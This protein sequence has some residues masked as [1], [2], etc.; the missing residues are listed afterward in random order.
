[1]ANENPILN[2]PY[3]EPR[4]HYATNL[5]GELDY[6]SVVQGRRLFR[7][8][9]PAIPVR[10]RGQRHLMGVNDLPDGTPPSDLPGLLKTNTGTCGAW[11]D[12]LTEALHDQGVSGAYASTIAP[13]QI[14]VNQLMGMPPPTPQQL[15]PNA[16][17]L[18]LYAVIKPNLPGQGNP[19]PKN[20]FPG[21]MQAVNGAPPLAV[22]GLHVVVVVNGVNS[23][24][25][26]SYGARD[27][28][29]NLGAAEQA[30]QDAA[31]QRWHYAVQYG[32]AGGD[33]T[34]DIPAK[35]GQLEVTFSGPPQ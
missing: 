14:A 19:N 6:E 22:S 29:A 30:W 28:G 32:Q 1:M 34:K 15:P 33:A 21:W 7:E 8:A 5:D 25:D 4:L 17:Y 13:N 18:G 35:T 27:D 11:A 10:Q 16:T 3:T 26:V 2:N 24:F 23:V 9:V 12:F 20:T 31:L